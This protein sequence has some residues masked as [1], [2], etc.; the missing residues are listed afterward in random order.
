MTTCAGYD[1]MRVVPVGFWADWGVNLLKY[2]VS[3]QAHTMAVV[4][5]Q[6]GHQAG[7]HLIVMDKME[8]VLRLAVMV[9]EKFL[10]QLAESDRDATF[11]VVM[12]RAADLREALQ[13]SVTM[14]GAIEAAAFVR[15]ES[16]Y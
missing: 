3:V 15:N 6:T 10:E 8:D 16:D 7:M 1:D 4:T 12:K 5:S 14:A 13:H 11:L 2:I 9:N